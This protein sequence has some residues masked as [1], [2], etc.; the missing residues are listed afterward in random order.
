MGRTFFRGANLID[1]LHKPK[2]NATVVVEGERITAVGTNGKMPKP[3]AQDTVYDLHGKSLMPGMVQSHYHVAYA[4]ISDLNDID[5]KYQPTHLALIAAKNAELL[6][7]SG[8]TG[9]AGAGTLHNIDVSLKKAIN[10]GLIPGPRFLAAGRDVVTTGDSVDNHPEFWKMKMEGLA[11][12]CDGPDE[13]RKAIRAEIKQG[14]DMIKLY[15][16]GGHGL[17]WPIETMTMSQDEI[18]AASNAT[19]ERGKKIRGHICSKKGIKAAIKAK[20]DLIDHGDRMDE[21]CIDLMA[22]NGT[23][24][25]P[26][27][28][29][30]WMVVEEHKRSG[31]AMWNEIEGM[32]RGV[33]NFAK[34]LPK[35]NK[36]GVKLLVGDDFGISIMPHGDYGKEL[37][38]YVKGAG[39]DPLDVIRWATVNGADLLGMKDDLGSIEPG[40]LAD[41][42]V[43]DGNPAKDITVLQDRDNLDVIMKGGDMFVCQLSPS[44]VQ[45]KA[46]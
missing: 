3:T 39:I 18:E 24:L 21:E 42:L 20:V 8:F 34:M 46:A 45:L 35:A 43:V 33:E 1:G 27:M 11:H 22:K 38:A 2:A 12:I 10:S 13:F 32:T 19:H 5:M 36:A 40:K 16:T 25:T 4:N 17:P 41:L 44:K 29:F 23:F 14:V 9:A 7:R 37:E 28:Y 6:L 26:S 30:P 31:E 15:P